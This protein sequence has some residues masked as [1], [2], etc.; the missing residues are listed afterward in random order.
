MSAEEIEIAKG[1]SINNEMSS[2]AAASGGWGDGR[3]AR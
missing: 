3:P 2:G 1:I